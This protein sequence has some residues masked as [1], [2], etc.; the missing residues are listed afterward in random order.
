VAYVVLSG[1]LAL[2]R[3]LDSPAAASEIA[4]FVADNYERIRM[5]AVARGELEAMTIVARWLRER[6]PGDGHLIHLNGPQLDPAAIYAASGADA[7][8]SAG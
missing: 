2:V 4:A 5:R 3:E 6:A 8:F 7:R 1:R